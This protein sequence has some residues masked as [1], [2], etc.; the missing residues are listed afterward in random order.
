[1]SVTNNERRGEVRQVRRE[2]RKS[3]KR[4]RTERVDGPGQKASSALINYSGCV[5]RL[6]GA[7]CPRA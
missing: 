3:D 7:A 5:S 6:R 2:E 1:M 4:W